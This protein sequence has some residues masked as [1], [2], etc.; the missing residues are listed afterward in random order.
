MW[1]LLDF[2]TRRGHRFPFYGPPDVWSQVV[3]CAAPRLRCAVEAIDDARLTPFWPKD[4]TRAAVKGFYE[5][6][7]LTSELSEHEALTIHAV[8]ALVARE[9]DDLCRIERSVSEGRWFRRIS[10]AV[11]ACGRALGTTDSYLDALRRVE[12]IRSRL[13]RDQDPSWA[14]SKLPDTQLGRFEQQVHKKIERW[15]ERRGITPEACRYL[16]ALGANEPESAARAAQLLALLDGRS[17]Q[18][19]SE[20]ELDTALQLAMTVEAA[21]PFAQREL[22][23]LERLAFCRMVHLEPLVDALARAEVR[24]R[25][26]DYRALLRGHR[27]AIERFSELL[28]TAESQGQ[29][30]DALCTRAELVLARPQFAAAAARA[31]LHAEL[32]LAPELVALGNI[33]EKCRTALDLARPFEAAKAEA[34]FVLLKD[35]LDSV[36]AVARDAPVI[37]QRRDR[38]LEGFG[39][40]ICEVRIHVDGRRGPSQP[41]ALTRTRDVLHAAA[42]AGV[43]VI[44][45][46]PPAIR[47]AG[48]VNVNYKYHEDD[49]D[50]L[51]RDLEA[52]AP[53]EIEV[54]CRHSDLSQ[55]EHSMRDAAERGGQ[56]MLV[57]APINF[58]SNHWTALVVSRIDGIIQTRYVDPKQESSEVPLEVQEALRSAFGYPG[59]SFAINHPGQA[60]NTSC[61]PLVVHDV[62]M[63]ARHWVETEGR[64]LRELPAPPD[65]VTLR[66]EQ[67]TRID[68]GSGSFWLQQQWDLGWVSNP[69]V[70]AFE[71]RDRDED[72]ICAKLARLSDSAIAA[73]V[74]DPSPAQL[75]RVLPG[76]RMAALL[77]RSPYSTPEFLARKAVQRE[78]ALRPVRA[79]LRELSPEVRSEFLRIIKKELKRSNQDAVRASS[80]REG[81]R[82]L[83][84]TIPLEKLAPFFSKT[85]TSDEDIATAELEFEPIQEGVGLLEVEEERARRAREAEEEAR[86]AREALALFAPFERFAAAPDR[87]FERQR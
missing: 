68:D 73:L 38:A 48:G 80:Y 22:A 44:R 75:L 8:R 58:H 72:Q 41:V 63:I 30:L 24:S 76:A 33:L 11:D 60:D 26:A 37:A 42:Q 81:I 27:G 70:E 57:I 35:Q 6:L 14:F 20:G 83:R 66:R 29:R 13:V 47:A 21:S 43:D 64:L 84:A 4:A 65:V 54:L 67:A 45:L 32:R 62:E 25:V 39:R 23:A 86:R 5:G 79:L 56:R 53:N 71:V 2:A 17:S 78:A 82:Y 46:A 77:R 34:L 87:P 15:A 1:A 12:A 52:L 3:A 55:L 74:A 69:D 61:G 19:A 10:R 7:P 59:L 31:R 36:D 85:I 40:E 28:V 9:V 18:L 51:L 16:S 49:L 50:H